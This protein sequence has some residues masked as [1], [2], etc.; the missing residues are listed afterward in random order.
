MNAFA[1]TYNACVCRKNFTG[2]QVSDR[3]AV[4]AEHALGKWVVETHEQTFER[5]TQAS[6]APVVPYLK[7]WVGETY[8]Q[9]RQNGFVGCCLYHTA[10]HGFLCPCLRQCRVHLHDVH[11]HTQFQRIGKAPP[12]FDILRWVILVLQHNGITPNLLH[13]LVLIP[14]RAVLEVFEA[15]YNVVNVFNNFLVDDFQILIHEWR[16]A[17][18]FLEIL[19]GERTEDVCYFL[20]C[21]VVQEQVDGL[22]FWNG[23]YGWIVDEWRNGIFYHNE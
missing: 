1:Q 2:L 16:I 12:I 13:N 8:H 20:C 15:C 7:Q 5:S 4:F 3:I 17:E 11:S 9:R 10:C 19:I 6:I 23:I 21:E 14:F 22:Q 18:V